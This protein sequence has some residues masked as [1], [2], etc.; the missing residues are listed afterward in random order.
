MQVNFSINI[1][2]KLVERI[3]R[4][5]TKRNTI[6]IVL[7]FTVAVTTV[8]LNGEAIIKPRTFSSGDVIYASS[9]NENFDILYAKVNELDGKAGGTPVGTIIVYAGTGQIPN[10]WL[11]CDGK[12]YSISEYE[13]L[14]LQIGTRYGGSGANFSVPDLRGRVIIGVTETFLSSDARFDMNGLG[15]GFAGAT[16]GKAKYKLDIEEL[17]KHGH[18]ILLDF[19]NFQLGSTASSKK[20]LEYVQKLS[21]PTD[22]H[23]TIGY[24]GP[25]P[26]DDRSTA[27]AGNGTPFPIIQHSMA[28]NY[29]IKY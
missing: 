2:D 5:F 26:Y 19:F 17:P 4:F 14:Y 7:I 20:E 22:T 16:G 11:L 15:F 29:L 1:D 12:S 21:N 27:T 18:D 25:L 3:K 10:G 28:L 23:L 9:I 6:V 8:I 24:V 13:G